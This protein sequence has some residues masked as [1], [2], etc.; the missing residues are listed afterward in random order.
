MIPIWLANPGEDFRVDRVPP[1]I[2]YVTAAGKEVKL[3]ILEG[4]VL[5]ITGRSAD[6]VYGVFH[7]H[8]ILFRQEIAMKVRGTIIGKTKEKPEILGAVMGTCNGD[9]GSCKQDCDHNG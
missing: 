1:S 6:C 3:N 7:G 4:C 2:D 9:C 5:A 8:R